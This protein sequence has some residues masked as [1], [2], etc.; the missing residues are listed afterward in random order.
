MKSIIVQNIK[1]L[2]KFSM[3]TN[4]LSMIILDINLVNKVIF[5]FN[6]YFYKLNKKSFHNKIFNF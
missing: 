1:L 6:I 3:I 2:I 5:N 4:F